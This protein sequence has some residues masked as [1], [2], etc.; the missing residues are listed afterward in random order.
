MEFK[1]FIFDKHC[2]YIVD[3]NTAVWSKQMKFKY[4]DYIRGV[5]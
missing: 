4:G 2:T 3:P 1:M 5:Y